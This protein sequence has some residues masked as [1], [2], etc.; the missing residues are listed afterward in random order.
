MF[1]QE[2]P[3]SSSPS[4]DRD[5][6]SSLSI[7]D[8]PNTTQLPVDTLTDSKK[9]TPRI[10]DIIVMPVRADRWSSRRLRRA[11]APPAEGSLC[12]LLRQHPGVSLFV[13]P[14]GW[15][16]R[17]SEFLDARFHE[18]PACESPRPVNVA[19]SCP[20]RRGFLRPSPTITELSTALTEILRPTSRHVVVNTNAVHTV[21]STLWPAAFS[22]PLFHPELHLFY[23]DRA[24]LRAVRTPMLWNFPSSP[25]AAH[26]ATNLPMMGYIG[27]N[28]LAMMRQ[29]APRATTVDNDNDPVLRLQIAR[30]KTLMP[31]NANH[32]SH[33]VAIFLAMAQRHFYPLL[34]PSAKKEAQW[35]SSSTA[36]GRSLRPD[37]K[38]VKL[39]LLTHD[40]ATGEFIV[41]TAR[42]TAQ[43]LQKFDRPRE[44]PLDADGKAV[45]LDIEYARIPIW[46]ILGLRERLGKALGQDMV[47]SFDTTK[48][49]TWDEEDEVKGRAKT[50][51]R[52]RAFVMSDEATDDDDD[53]DDDDEGIVIKRRR[54]VENSPVGVVA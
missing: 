48:M 37:F 3:P 36:G 20:P 51:K 44:T 54:L 17:H 39:R 42:V 26:D 29:T 1:L 6:S 19:G 46:P 5:K 18:L 2:S 4:P 9:K 11:A 21:L 49:E 8:A 14:V 45:G 16:D 33:F 43:Y 34:A 25:L 13:R 50:T 12:A 52:K 47:G 10:A 53:D 35:W 38:D 32:D 31:A 22:K 24:Y 15:T 41:Y 23:G 27:K 7:D 28:H 40:E 30:S